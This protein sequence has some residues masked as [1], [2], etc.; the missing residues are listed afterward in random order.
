MN[1]DEIRSKAEQL[2]QQNYKTEDLTLPGN[3]AKTIEEL[4]IHQ[5]E[6]E[7]QN[8]ELRRIQSELQA[9]QRKYHNLYTLAPVGYFTFDASG[10]IIELNFT[11]TQMIRTPRKRLIGRTMTPYLTRESLEAFY[12]HCHTTL[13]QVEGASPVTCEL[14]LA[15]KD[16]P[17]R[18]MSF[19]SIPV[20]DEQGEPHQIW[21]AMIDITERKLAENQLRE[22]EAKWAAL[23]NSTSDLIWAIDRNH[24][25]IRVNDALQTVVRQ[26]MKYNLETGKDVFGMF[27]ANLYALWRGYFS[28]AF[29]GE[30]VVDELEMWGDV[31]EVMIN[32]FMTGG[33]IVAGV[34]VYAHNISERKAMEQIL[35]DRNRELD[36]FAHS[37]AHDLQA[38]LSM[39]SG[40]ADYLL[41]H[42]SGFDAE[43]MLKLGEKIDRA[44]NRATKIVD[45]LFF[46]ASSGNE[47]FV[48]VPL[49]MI[50]IAE[51]AC[52]RL[53]TMIKQTKAQIELPG[54]LAAA[55]GYAPWVEKV[56]LNLLSIAIKSGGSAPLL[57]IGSE[58]QANGLACFRI[59]TARQ[60]SANSDAVEGLSKTDITSFSGI[61]LSV[62]QRVME[63]MNGS[64]SIDPCSNNAHDYDCLE[65]SFTLPAATNQNNSNRY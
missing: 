8:E 9:A 64:I 51:R 11:A 5:I 42:G 6:L 58:T 36:A 22:S 15:G 1:Q 47:A 45:E 33:D 39:L 40:Y 2:L 50:D 53:S 44:A 54:T 49:K 60:Q 41:R 65:F 26:E 19:E 17:P 23:A 10:I 13:T 14:V 63:R 56:W 18:V 16:N 29:N 34:V 37:I 20:F 52:D 24:T 43:E 57:D 55:M 28:R 46:I 62:I 59:R 35:R 3:L 4:Q 7:L 12:R 61:E 30:R 21:S 48:P 27:P 38:P 25:I 31:L 32:P